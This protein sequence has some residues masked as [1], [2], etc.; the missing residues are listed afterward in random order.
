MLSLY[1]S[2]CDLIWSFDDITK[3]KIDFLY[4][5]RDSFWGQLFIGFFLVTKKSS[6]R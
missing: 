3:Q 4:L 1:C 2:I 6:V 5:I